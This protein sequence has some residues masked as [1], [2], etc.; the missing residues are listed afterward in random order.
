MSN[1][2]LGAKDDPNAPYNQEEKQVM[3][4]FSISGTDSINV[5][6]KLSDEEIKEKICEYLKETHGND[7]EIEHLEEV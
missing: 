2:P 7:I 5:N 3:F 4:S 6:T 1:Y